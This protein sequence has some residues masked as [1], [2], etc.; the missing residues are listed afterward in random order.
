MEPEDCRPA[1]AWAQDGRKPPIARFAAEAGTLRH[2]GRP[3]AVR[4]ASAILRAQGC[5]RLRRSTSTPTATSVPWRVRRRMGSWSWLS[6]AVSSCAMP[7]R[8]WPAPALRG[9]PTIGSPDRAHLDP[10][11]WARGRPGK[12]RHRHR[13]GLAAAAR[14][15]TRPSPE[16]VGDD[17]EFDH[18][19]LVAMLDRLKLTAIRTS[20][21]PCWMR[22]GPLEDGPC[23]RRWGSWIQRE[24]APTGT[25]AGISMASKIAQ[26]NPSCA[27]SPACDR[28]AEAIPGPG[29]DPVNWRP[30]DRF[31]HGNT[32]LLLGPPGTGRNSLAV[33]LGREAIQQLT[34]SSSP[35]P[36]WGRHAGQG[37]WR[38]RT[39]TSSSRRR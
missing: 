7:A 35:P 37:S 23:A 8:S 29:R 10:V 38:W 1:R 24:I 25:S 26:F 18:E 15:N 20:S 31:A 16:G 11:W 5:A 17:R 39:M 22:G 14:R 28:A 34:C 21:I 12:L 27:S 3:R 33:S 36:P 6:P 19:V 30:A 9:A 4:A 13:S 32:T 2:S